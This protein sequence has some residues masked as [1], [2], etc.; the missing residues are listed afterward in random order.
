M[1]FKTTM[2]PW[3]VSDHVRLQLHAMNS[4]MFPLGHQG[5]SVGQLAM[6]LLKP[7]NNNALSQIICSECNH[8]NMQID[9]KYPY[10]LH[11]D[12]STY[13][14]TKEWVASLNIL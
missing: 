1:M 4:N 10:T 2:L 5:A 3:N 13:S 8:E 11:A 6:Q 14:S 9:V 12:S 7:E